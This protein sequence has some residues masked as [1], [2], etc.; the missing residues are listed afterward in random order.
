LNPIS[1]YY[2][3]E[4][5][6]PVNSDLEFEPVDI[7]IKTVKELFLKNNLRFPILVKTL[8]SGEDVSVNQKFEEVFP[9]EH[10]KIELSFTPKIN[11]IKP[12]TGKLSFKI[13]WVIK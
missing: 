3:E 8:F 11:A 6:Q 12:I 1:V 7:G 13:K 9:N 2:D 4:L 10:E 5:T